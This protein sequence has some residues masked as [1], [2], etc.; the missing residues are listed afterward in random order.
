MRALTPATSYISA[1]WYIAGRYGNTLSQLKALELAV[2]KEAWGHSWPALPRTPQQTRQAGHHRER[3]LL[4]EMSKGST[5]MS[6]SGQA[7]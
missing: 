4:G 7:P 5:S 1:P 3:D 2:F 6:L